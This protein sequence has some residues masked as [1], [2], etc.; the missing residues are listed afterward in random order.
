MKK[1]LF[2]LTPLVLIILLI[3]LGFTPD[4]PFADLKLKYTDEHSQ[5]IPIDD[6]DVHYRIEGQGPPVL[7]IHGTASSL[8]TWDDW[9]NMLTNTHTVI[10]LD[11]PAFGLTGPRADR[12]YSM[13]SYVGF[14]H[15]FIRD[16][17][18]TDSITIAGNSLGGAIAW[19]YTI[20]HP[21][22]VAKL[23]LVDATGAPRDKELPFIFEIA[24]TPGM[25][26][27]LEKIT[28][29]SVI[30]SNLE[31]VYF[32]DSKITDA[33]VDRYYEMTHR[34]GNRQA[35][36]DRARLDLM[37]DTDRIGEIQCPT[38]I[39][40]GREDLWIPVEDADFFNQQIANSK[41]II[42]DNAGHVPMEEIPDATCKD[43]IDFLVTNP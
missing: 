41:V 36:V 13:D 27:L 11:L 17:V 14:L 42:Y 15:R 7:L 19:N 10:R 39:L 33:L 3:R 16:V 31:E 18:D 32:D 25:S 30:K 28:P 12:D 2:I 9:T 1:L 23:I 26:W 34:P 37:N 29:K 43:V 6:M 20:A 40:W 24:R 35:F 4:I 22:R 5:F 21:E 8:H 38:L